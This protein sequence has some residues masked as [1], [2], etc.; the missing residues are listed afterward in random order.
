MLI[1]VGGLPGTGKTTVARQLAVERSA[2][3]LRIDVIE[4]A[5]RVADQGAGDIGA[6]GYVVAYE[7]AHSNLLLGRPVIADCVNPLAITRQAWRLVAQRAGCALLEV[8][9][10]CSDAREHRRR[11]ETRTADIQGF[12]LP[13]WESVVHHHYEPW[14]TD[15]LVVDTAALSV[16]A[17]VARISLQTP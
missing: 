12:A 17:A 14:T 7:V 11:V 4:Q 3:Y 16:A 13:S 6:R 9:L 5:L 15:R 1:V 10:V 2:V 8:E